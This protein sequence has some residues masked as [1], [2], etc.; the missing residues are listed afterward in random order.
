VL[1]SPKPFRQ[2]NEVRLRTE[3]YYAH[4]HRDAQRLVSSRIFLLVSASR[5]PLSRSK[6][7]RV[8]RFGTRSLFRHGVFVSQRKSSGLILKMPEEIIGVAQ[9]NLHCLARVVH[10][11]ALDSRCR[12]VGVE[13]GFETAHTVSLKRDGRNSG[14]WPAGQH[15]PD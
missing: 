2:S 11:R 7:S 8:K 1:H 3:T 12:I 9:R 14:L 13:V 5:I 6:K 15:L 4:A 10:T